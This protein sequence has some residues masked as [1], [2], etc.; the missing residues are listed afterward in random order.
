MFRN[1]TRYYLRLESL[2]ESCRCMLDAQENDRLSLGSD[3]ELCQLKSS[4]QGP[5]LKCIL[6][7]KLE[8]SSAIGILLCQ[9]I[10]EP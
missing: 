1:E 9:N 2:L 4:K 10:E 6:K 3:E 8:F 7:G 5:F